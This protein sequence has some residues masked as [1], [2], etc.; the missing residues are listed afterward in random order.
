MHRLD[1]KSVS[2]YPQTEMTMAYV[3][4]KLH[5][6]QPSRGDEVDVDLNVLGLTVM[7]GV[8]CHVESTDIVTYGNRGKGKR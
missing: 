8:G 2:C 5:H 1:Q 6:A 4:Y 3:G 7:N